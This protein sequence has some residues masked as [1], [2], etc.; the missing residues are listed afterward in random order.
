MLISKRMFVI[1]GRKHSDEILQ[2]SNIQN[3]NYKIQVLILL[4]Y[5]EF[6][7]SLDFLWKPKNILLTTK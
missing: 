6:R 2:I 7:N 1:S 5:L 4:L 3:I